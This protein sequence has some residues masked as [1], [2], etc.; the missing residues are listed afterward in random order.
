LGDFYF[1][2]FSKNYRSS[3]KIRLLFPQQKLRITL[4][5]TNRS[6]TFCAIFYK[7]IWSPWREVTKTAF[8]LSV[9]SSRAV[10]LFGKFWTLEKR[11]AFEAKKK[12]VEKQTQDGSDETGGQGTML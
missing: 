5:K 3:Q 2:Q 8:L 12:S 4:D 9:P 7:L 6:A 1:G 10:C 11:Q